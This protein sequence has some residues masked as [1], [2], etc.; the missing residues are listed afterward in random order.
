VNSGGGRNSSAVQTMGRR[1]DSMGCSR[2][3][4]Q[5]DAPCGGSMAGGGPE[6]VVDGEALRRKAAAEEGAHSNVAADGSSSKAGAL[7][8]DIEVVVMADLNGDR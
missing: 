2:T 4:G 3:A 6:T 1:W 8:E 7:E 5:C